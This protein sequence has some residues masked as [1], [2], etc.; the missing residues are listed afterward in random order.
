MDF[1]LTLILRSPVSNLTRCLS[2]PY[3]M[4]SDQTWL[5]KYLD[6]L[7]TRLNFDTS[8]GWGK[9]VIDFGDHGPIFKV[10]WSSLTKC[11]SAPYLM[12]SDQTWLNV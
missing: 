8:L 9:Q 3:F 5:V 1:A 10:T 6:G 7:K 4:N 2:V 12:N 11:L